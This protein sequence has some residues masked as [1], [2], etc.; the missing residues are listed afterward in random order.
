LLTIVHLIKDGQSAVT[1]PHMPA[2]IGRFEIH[3][4]SAKLEGLT[5]ETVGLYGSVQRPPPG[6][7]GWYCPFHW[8]NYSS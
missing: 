1:G 4:A 7:S 8:M 5:A 3:R 6:D 2:P